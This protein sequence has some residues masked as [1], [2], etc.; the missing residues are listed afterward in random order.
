MRCKQVWGRGIFMI[1][2]WCGR[3]QPTAVGAI[4]R[5]VVLATVRK[6]C[7][8]NKAPILLVWN[9]AAGMKEIC[10]FP[11]PLASHSRQARELA[12]SLAAS[13]IK[14]ACWDSTGEFTMVVRLRE[15][16]WTDQPC[17]YPGPES[18]LW[19]GLPQHPLNLWTVGACEGYKPIYQK[20]AGSS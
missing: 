4:P 6:Q 10:P 8:S 15:N 1:S 14:C 3:S 16:W 9:A 2:D 11:L 7:E 19:V 17:Y 18:G 20:R 5:L 12:L 13:C